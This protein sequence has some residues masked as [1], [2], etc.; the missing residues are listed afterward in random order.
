MI[1][2][3]SVPAGKQPLGFKNDDGSSVREVSVGLQAFA[4]SGAPTN[5][6]TYLCC[7]G[8]WTAYLVPRGSA[9][10]LPT[11]W[12]ANL[13]LAYPIAVGPA[14]V[15]LLG[16]IT[17]VF[18]N[19]IVAGREE[20]WSLEQQAGYPDTIFDVNQPKTN[21]DYG[22]VTGRTSPRLFRAAVR[23]SF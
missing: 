15:S 16:S 23:V 6:L 18:N 4:E 22:K 2:D 19:Q 7:F 1:D 10:R 11:Q 13:S 3:S 12:G 17:N 9:G 21:D 5:K 20:A 8:D 14:T